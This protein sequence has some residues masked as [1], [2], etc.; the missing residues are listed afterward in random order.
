MECLQALVEEKSVP[1]FNQDKTALVPQN[2]FMVQGMEHTD[3][4]SII[5]LTVP[6]LSNTDVTSP[7]T[8]TSATGEGYSLVRLIDDAVEEESKE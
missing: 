6:S 3:D 1:C 4:R 8:P 7:P 2:V 5:L